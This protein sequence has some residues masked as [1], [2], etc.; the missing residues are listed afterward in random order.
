MKNTIKVLGFIVLTA[1]IG[2]GFLS[3]S[4][5]GAGGGGGGGGGPV[6]N[7]GSGKYA[8]KDV[9]GNSYSLSV[10]SDAK[11]AIKGDGFRM[12]LTTRDGKTRVVTGSVVDINN[13]GT[14]KLKENGSNIE[15][16]AKVAGTS[17]LN[18]VIGNDDGASLTLN[19]GTKFI[20][21]TFDSIFL[22]ATRWGDTSDEWSGENWGSGVSVLIKDFPANVSMLEGGDPT[23]Y[24]M[25]ISG[26]SDKSIANLRL[27]IQ[28][29]TEDN[30]WVWLGS[31]TQEQN[32]TI[33]AGVP[34]NHTITIDSL[35]NLSS[36]EGNGNFME[37]K[38][39]ILQ[40]TNLINMYNYDTVQENYGTISD[41]DLGSIMATI[42]DFNIKLTDTQRIAI[43]GN[44]GD[45]TYCIQEDGLSVDYRMARWEL[46]A[47]A[48]SKAKQIGSKLE[49]TVAQSI[50]E[51]TLNFVWQD[52][53]RELWWQDSTWLCGGVETP[54]GSNNWPFELADGV[55]WNDSTKILT[56][57]LDSVIEDERFYN[58]TELN[59]V[60]ACWHGSNAGKTNIDTF[61]IT[62]AEIVSN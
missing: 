34:F 62:K 45:Y 29:L 44:M 17:S 20:P 30:K 16:T 33:T 5:S 28:G 36:V 57:D 7:M 42:S 3:C 35:A 18:T 61:K 1:I 32:K 6:V 56:I 59:L 51:P 13:D 39:V 31:S 2:F 14:L 52:P 50:G 22:R 23:R 48:L 53:V 54:P 12:S 47:E 9:L 19:D 37:Y 27:E 55:T 21:R 25:T 40:V 46:Q 8:G 49:I 24:S 38:E 41:T 4:G 10:G 11:A 43:Q 58:S 15:F 60:I 26:T